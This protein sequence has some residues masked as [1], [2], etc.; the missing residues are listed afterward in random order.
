M[1]TLEKVCIFAL[2]KTIRYIEIKYKDAERLALYLS[3]VSGKPVELTRE[4]SE[5]FPLPPKVKTMPDYVDAFVVGNYIVAYLEKDGE[6][7]PK[8]RNRCLRR[9]VMGAHIKE[10]REKKN[11]TLGDMETLT[12][13]R[14]K[15]LENI[16]LGRYDATLDVLANIADALNCDI[17]FEER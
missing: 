11:L 10:V 14:A 4:P 7:D 17:K 16:E 8:Y 5:L 12:G 13:I 15:N 6:A 9:V 3:S 1:H 2:M